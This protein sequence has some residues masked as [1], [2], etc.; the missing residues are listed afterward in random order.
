MHHFSRVVLPQ[1]A[2]AFEEHSVKLEIDV[3]K[4][5]KRC[6]LDAKPSECSIKEEILLLVIFWHQ[7]HNT[8]WVVGE[9]LFF[10]EEIDGEDALM[11]DKHFTSNYWELLAPTI[12]SLTLQFQD[13]EEKSQERLQ[14]LLFLHNLQSLEMSGGYPLHCLHI[15]EL[16]MLQGA[17]IV[18]HQQGFH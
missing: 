5:V 13:S 16:V 6:S 18:Q 17:G 7:D 15:C 12:T 2:A 10:S 14:P 1:L 4:G 9:R 3:Q 11:F 8:W